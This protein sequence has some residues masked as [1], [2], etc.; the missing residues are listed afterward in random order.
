LAHKRCHPLI[1]SCVS[2]LMRSQASFIAAPLRKI[3]ALFRVSLPPDYSRFSSLGFPEILPLVLLVCEYMYATCLD[4]LSFL[5]LWFEVVCHSWKIH[6]HYFFKYFSFSIS[7]SSPSKIVFIGLFDLF[8]LSHIAFFPSFFSLH[9]S[10][11]FSVLNFLLVLYFSLLLFLICCLTY[12]F[13][14]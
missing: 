5:K 8:I 10:F 2:L 9:F 7:L 11:E 3:L 6:N 1:L 13:N 12:L 4:F 14:F